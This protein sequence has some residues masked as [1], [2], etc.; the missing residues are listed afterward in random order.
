MSPKIVRQSVATS[1]KA[2]SLLKNGGVVVMPTDTIYGMMASALDREAVEKV[3]AIRKRDL[4]KPVIIL[5]R[6]RGDLKKFSVVLDTASRKFLRTVWP[7]KV[8][9]VFPIQND[10]DWEYLHRGTKTLAF[11][12][13]TDESLRAFLRLTGPLIAPSANLAGKLPAT[14]ITSAQKYFADQV[15]LYI[16]GGIR[17]SAPSTLV[18]WTPTGIKIL[19]E[20]AVALDTK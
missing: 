2:V 7:G 10:P 19:R 3:Y 12:L 1:Q 13:P 5:I 11:R 16:D 8:S 17:E 4:H 14:T 15:D 6:D 9:V 18:A 20:G